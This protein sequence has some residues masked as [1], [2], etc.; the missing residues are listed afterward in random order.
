MKKPRLEKK[1]EEIFWDVFDA[2]L[3]LDLAKGYLKWTL[4]D[5]SRQ[6]KVSRTLIYY[7]FGKSKEAIMN[8]AID[9]LGKEYFGLSEDR[10]QLWKDKNIYESIRRSRILWQ[11]S[12]HTYSFYILR[13]QQDNA[14]GA[15]LRDLEKMYEKKMKIF[16]P[17]IPSA[18]VE[19]TRATF[20]GL[21]VSPTLSEEGLQIAVDLVIGLLER[22]L[23][24]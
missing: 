12:P 22:S 14:V 1:K 13:R 8:A 20:F 7:Y 23:K 11:K 24:S 18:M 21:A 2:V 4:S 5:L 10:L 17:N 16:Y 9:A 6:S 3:K 19:A 15:R